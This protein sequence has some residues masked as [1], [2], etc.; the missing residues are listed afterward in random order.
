MTMKYV[1]IGGS[2]G[3]LDP[4]IEIVS[5]LHPAIDAAFL[6]VRHISPNA[7]SLLPGIL[8]SHSA[9]PVVDAEDG[10]KILAGTIHIAPAGMTTE[11]MR[12]SQGINRF[13][14][15]PIEPGQKPTPSINDSLNSGA[16]LFDQDCIA[17][18]LSGYLDDGTEG[19]Q[20]LASHHGFTIV[21]SPSDADADSMPW[22]V[23]HRDSPDFILRA[24]Q[25]GDIL[26]ELCRSPVSGD[27]ARVLQTG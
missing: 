12:D 23:I 13:R 22:N 26:G 16:Q 9:L 1:V 4:I 2:W 10:A 17:V 8:Q 19:A 24:G 20:T 14:L 27:F 5:S 6:I 7:P 21:Q 11:V 3:S 18:I 25:I 15:G